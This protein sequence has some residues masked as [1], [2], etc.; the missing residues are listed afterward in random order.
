MA[1][2]SEICTDCT[3]FCTGSF[4]SKIASPSQGSNYGASGNQVPSGR[5]KGMLRITPPVP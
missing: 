4:W 3:D 1:A 5:L 2:T